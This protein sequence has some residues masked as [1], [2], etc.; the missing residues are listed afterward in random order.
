M[1][2]TLIVVEMVTIVPLLDFIE[3]KVIQCGTCSLER[4]SV[5]LKEVK[6]VSMRQQESLVFFCWVS[7]VLGNILIQKQ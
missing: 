1:F 7:S 5:C 6:D 3:N 4:F 2:P